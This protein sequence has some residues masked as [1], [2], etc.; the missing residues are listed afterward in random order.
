MKANIISIGNSKGIR[1]PKAILKQCG[2]TD[3]VELSVED[4][5]LV[6]APGNH[7]REGWEEAF[8]RAAK[9]KSSDDDFSDW[10]IPNKWDETEWTW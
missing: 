7:P 3:S 1:I 4:G 10:D 6:I 9:D 5:R 8:K 2:F